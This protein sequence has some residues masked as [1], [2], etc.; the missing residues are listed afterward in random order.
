VPSSSG[1]GP[2]DG[3]G[4]DS[5]GH[6]VDGSGSDAEASG[7]QEPLDSGALDSDGAGGRVFPDTGPADAN[8]SAEDTGGSE[9]DAA[10]CEHPSVVANC[11]DGW[12]QIP[13]GCFVMGSPESE[14][15][16]GLVSEAQVAV[17]LT[18]SL[19]VGQ[20]E[21]TQEQWM[22]EGLPNPSG[23][24][25]A[26]SSVGMGDCTDDVRC[27]V[28]NV[29]WFEAVA[30]A[31]LLSEAHDPPLAPCYEL[32]GCSGELGTG[33]T[34][35]DASLS[36][37]TVYE[38]EGFRLP[39]DAEWEYA[40]RAGARGAFY[41]GDILVYEGALAECRPDPTLERIAWYCQNSQGTTHPVGGRE[42]NPWGL[43]DVL[44]N[45]REWVN[46]HND[47]RPSPA[48]VDP[49]GTVDGGSARYVRGGNYRTWASLCRLASQ[50]A[51]DWYDR[52]PGIGFRLARTLL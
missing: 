46:D 22:A 28:G 7:G 41:S 17:T 38:C 37:S 6:P 32:R 8:G 48:P 12:C 20:Y 3:G 40:A 2:R 9:F 19:V 14:W 1:D 39:T 35:V 10:G 49:R 30:F 29:T 26:G 44:G 31:N 27:P 24:H 21:V 52:A 51:A 42:P 43:Y 34:C 18:R 36:T 50:G 45:A 13:A 4:E 33:M 25:D 5:S 16:H 23:L 15:G 47:G 11:A